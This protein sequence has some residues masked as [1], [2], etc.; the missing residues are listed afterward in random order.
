MA[1]AIQGPRVAC[2]AYARVAFG[3][4]RASRACDTTAQSN[5]AHIRLLVARTRSYR[6]PDAEAPFNLPACVPLTVQRGAS[7]PLAEV[8]NH[9]PLGVMRENRSMRS[10]GAPRCGGT[11]VPCAR[12]RFPVAPRSGTQ[13]PARAPTHRQPGCGAQCDCYVGKQRRNHLALVA[14]LLALRGPQGVDV[15]A[16]ELSGAR[17]PR[18]L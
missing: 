14:P 2:T 6:H 8:A 13:G 3:E 12:P 16:G 4:L 18:H 11:R 10:A 1:Q 15:F 5:L 7:S 17:G 9:P